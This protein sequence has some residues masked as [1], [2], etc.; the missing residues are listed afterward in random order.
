MQ[1]IFFPSEKEII[2]GNLFLP[3]F[4][5]PPGVLLL[6]G[7]GKS[8]KERFTTLQIALSEKG[9]AS[10]A[11][12]FRGVGESTGRFQ[13]GSLKNRITDAKNALNILKKYCDPHNIAILGSSMGGYI[14]PLIAQ[15]D[16]GIRVLVMSA[17][18]AYNPEAEDKPLD[19]EFT[20]SISMSH[21]W[22]NSKSFESLKNFKGKALIV[23][24]EKDTVIPDE[25]KNEYKRII[26][27]KSSGKDRNIKD[28][29]VV[30]PN[31]THNLIVPKDSHEKKIKGIWLQ[32]IIDFLTKTLQKNI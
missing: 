19:E 5:N 16:S 32:M 13:D 8:N 7:A 11:I 25:I 1:T 9:I 3:A 30:I 4:S 26:E 20:N 29:Y 22:K 10:L 12:D 23:Y 2:A 6:H 28:V 27:Q 21:S 15:K 24:G 14:A 18:A 31:G 17:S